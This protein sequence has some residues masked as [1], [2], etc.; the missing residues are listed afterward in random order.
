MEILAGL[1]GGLGLFFL[2]IKAIGQNLQALAGPR[3]RRA[4]ARLTALP[5][6]GPVVGL[7][8]GALTQSTN[9]VTFIA[10]NMQMSGLLSVSHALPLIG[11]ANV[12]TAVLVLMATVDLRLAALLLLGTVGC[13]T[14]FNLD[15]GGRWRPALHAVVGVGLL[16]LGLAVLK[17]GA[18]PLRD[19]A[20]VREFLLFA[21]GALLAAFAAGVAVTLLAQSSST[22]SILAIALFKVKLL[23]FDQTAM[24][25]YGASLGSGLATYLLAGDLIGTTRR[26]VVYQAIFKTVGAVL[27]VTL[28]M[29]EHVTATP[30]VHALADRIADKPELHLGWLFAL[31]QLVTAVL[32]TP[33]QAPMVRLLAW[34]IPPTPREEL[35]RPQFI[36]DQAVSDPPGALVLAQREQDRLLARLPLLLDDTRADADPPPLP[37]AVLS[38]TARPVEARLDE[39]LQRLLGFGLANDALVEAVRQQ[40]RL[41]LLTD[42]RTTVADFVQAAALAGAVAPVPHLTEALHLLVERTA[43]ADNADDRS[44]LFALTEDRSD[45]MRRLR[46]ERN[47]HVPPELLHTITACFER[48]VWLL[49]G[50]LVLDDE[51]SAE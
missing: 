37:P 34:W 12:G 36:Y 48:A 50:I 5:A 40:A 6:A 15:A 39:F 26:L 51:R 14:Y 33:L 16:F 21:S 22:V 9:A 31:L 25:I 46:A 32:F 29:V 3:V 45:M 35:S 10:A 30:L 28:S 43:E 20:L 24:V 7:V 38:D 18:A 17:A 49:R 1:F 44:V 19:L 42:L 2:G 23:G 41:R 4:A 27:F 11:W 47:G 8:L 13:M